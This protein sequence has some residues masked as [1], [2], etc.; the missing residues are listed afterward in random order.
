[1]PISQ[2]VMVDAQPRGI[3]PG[4]SRSLP[5]GKKL[6][7]LPGLKAFRPFARRILKVAEPAGRLSIR[8]F[9]AYPA[10]INADRITILSANLWHDWPRYRHREERLDDF[11]RLVESQGA[12]IVLLQEVARTTGFRVDEWLS[13]RLGMGYIYSRANGHEDGIGFEEGLAVFSRFPL[14]KPQIQQLGGNSN[15]FVRRLALGATVNTPRGRLMIFSVH[16]GLARRQ[17]EAQLAH[18]KSWVA[19]QAGEL[20]FLV[21]G[22]FNAHEGSPQIRKVR[23]AWLD[24]FRHI[25]PSAEGYTHE[26]RW[27]WGSVIRRHRLDYVFFGANRWRWRVAEACHVDAPGGPHSDHRAVLVRLAPLGGD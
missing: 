11:A 18:L 4:L 14:T 17:N 21:G 23:S 1:M 16:L 9:P 5:L 12:D 26:L 22:D 20:P 19:R 7:A 25:H 24:T 27:P 3:A 2:E 15:P 10:S 8:S 6:L 13:E